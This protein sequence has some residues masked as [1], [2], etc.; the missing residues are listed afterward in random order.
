MFELKTKEMHCDVVLVVCSA[1]PSQGE[2]SV[3]QRFLW[4]YGQGCAPFLVATPKAIEGVEGANW[5]LDP[6][7]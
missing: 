3:E 4:F 6:S 1:L 5:G 2:R 7:H